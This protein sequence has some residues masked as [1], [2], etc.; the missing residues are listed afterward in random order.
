MNIGVV[1]PGAMGSF[2]SGLLARENKVTLL[3]RHKEDIESIRIQG[4]TELVSKVYFTTDPTE[5]KTVDLVLITTKAFDTEEAVERIAPHLN[6]S[7]S[8]LSL[9]NGLMNEEII[10]NFVGKER[11][12]GGVT[13]H[14]VTYI[15]AGKVR[16]AGIGETVIGAYPEGDPE[17]SE[18]KKT[19]ELLNKAGLKT[20]VSD[21]ILGHIWKKVIVNTGINPI[22]ALLGV[23]NGFLLDD[24][25]LLGVLKEV[26]EEAAE[27]ARKHTELPVDDP[28]EETKRV[29]K[30]TRDNR[31]S[32]LQDIE[33]KRKT[34]IDQINGAVIQ[35]AEEVDIS[36]PANRTLYGLLKG[37]E[38]AKI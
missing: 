14:G 1:G 35:K 29:A 36:V 4:E 33:N 26:V 34:E 15:E 24:E 11:T 37:I 20:E 3:G 23:K 30:N 32:M 27:V 22:T 28:F 8:V 18:V 9:Q 7:C 12:I 6:P 38:K 16:H 31:S 13:S 25:I 21:N 2:L 5:L 19:S 10:A 17:K